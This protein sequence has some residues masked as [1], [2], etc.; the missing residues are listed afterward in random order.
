R[1]NVAVGIVLN[2]FLLWDFRQVYALQR[3]QNLQSKGILEAMDM[4]SLV[5]TIGSLA[6]LQFNHPDWIIPEI[7]ID[8]PVLEAKNIKHPLI[9]QATS[10]AND[11]SLERHRIALI[12]G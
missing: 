4:L 7:A 3:W 12:T 10:I 1:L 2:M 11:Y 5:E 6:T 9:P 8:F